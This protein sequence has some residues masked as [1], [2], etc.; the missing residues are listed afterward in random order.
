MA[1]SKYIE[2]LIER[3]KPKPMGLYYWQSEMHKNEPPIDT[4]GVCDTV[5]GKFDVFC[6]TCGNRIDKDNYKLG[7]RRDG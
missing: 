2:E 5:I 1:N 6:A 7:A 3:D 4:C